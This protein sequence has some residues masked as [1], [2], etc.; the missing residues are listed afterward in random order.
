MDNPSYSIKELASMEYCDLEEDNISIFDFINY[1]KNHIKKIKTCD[2]SYKINL[3]NTQGLLLLEEEV[4]TLYF[5]INKDIGTIKAFLDDN[6]NL[7][8]KLST[9]DRLLNWTLEQREEKL[10]KNIYIKINKCPE[11]TQEDLLRIRKGLLNSTREKDK[12]LYR[13][14]SFYKKKSLERRRLKW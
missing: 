12:D 3:L 14:V 13:R 10:L 5:V 2:S 4:I 6:N 9:S 8:Y 1:Y 11:E 7:I